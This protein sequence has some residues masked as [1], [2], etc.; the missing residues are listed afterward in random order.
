MKKKP[1]PIYF[2]ILALRK[3]LNINYQ[4]IQIKKFLMKLNDALSI[5]PSSSEV[6]RTSES[7]QGESV[8]NK[9]KLYRI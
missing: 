9:T 7:R 5:G 3:R 6:M 1:K 8:F 2:L 4:S